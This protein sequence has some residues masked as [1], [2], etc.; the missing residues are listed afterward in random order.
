MKITRED[1]FWKLTIIIGLIL[2]VLNSLVFIMLGRANAD[3]GW[4]LYAS[5][6][7]YSGQLPY[8]DFAFTQT[9]LLPFIYGIFQHLISQ[10]IYLGR[11]TSFIFSL[12]AMYLA[13]KTARVRG[14]LMAGGITALL[15]ATFTYGIYYQS[16]TKT[17][18]LT[19]FFFLLAFFILTSGLK[20]DWKAILSSIILLLAILTRLSSLFFAIPFFIYAFFT[21]DAR[22]KIVLIALTVITVLPWLVLAM[23]NM[24]AAVWGLFGHHTSGWDSVQFT[25]RITNRLPDLITW[26]IREFSV[27]ALLWGV[28]LALHLNRI[29]ALIRH[30]MPLLLVTTASFLF[31]FPNLI[32]D[33]FQPEYFVPILFVSFPIL[34]I[35]FGK[36]VSQQAKINKFLP[37]AMLLIVFGA[38]LIQGW[39]SFIDVSGGSAPVQEIRQ[40]AALIRENTA[41]NDRI[42]ALEALWLAVESQRRVLPGMEMAQFSFYEMDTETANR[43]HLLNSEIA[44]NYIESGEPKIIILTDLD[45]DIFLDSTHS[46]EFFAS[47]EKN[48]QLLY[49][50]KDEFGQRAEGVKIYMR[51]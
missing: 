7:V 1:R 9:P 51:R 43:L 6:L 30:D 50:M 27:Y 23:Q 32:S 11:I 26:A 42:F 33:G 47:L 4:Y 12:L 14:G 2:F 15:S 20:P 10:S 39:R 29:Y 38:S 46:E 28:I 37:G 22:N 16:I 3:E 49:R 25:E 31:I 24:D 34:G 21:I 35:I 17:Y 19:S 5:K 48:Y 41:V 18:A 44:W 40:V 13:I 45:E 36:I 8:R